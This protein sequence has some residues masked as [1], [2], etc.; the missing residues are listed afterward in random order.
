MIRKWLMV[1]MAWL[2][3]APLATANESPNA[4]VLTPPDDQDELASLAAKLSVAKHMRLVLYAEHGEEISGL[5][6]VARPHGF[7][8]LIRYDGE[9]TLAMRIAFVA[10]AK[11]LEPGSRPSVLIIADQGRVFVRRG[12]SPGPIDGYNARLHAEVERALPL[13][14]DSPRV[15]PA[16]VQNSVETSGA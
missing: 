6:V 9:E 2:A 1:C 10:E 4:S 11:K 3:F 16:T 15:A 5:T 8:Q 12:Q 14:E 13:T 7:D